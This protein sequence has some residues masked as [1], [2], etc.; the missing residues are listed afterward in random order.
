MARRRAPASPRD[1]GATPTW[2]WTG[3]TGAPKPHLVYLLQHGLP[4]ETYPPGITIDWSD[5]YTLERF[6]EQAGLLRK[7]VPGP[8][9]PPILASRQIDIAIKVLW[10]PAKRPSD[11]A[12][13]RCFR[14]IME[15][16]LDDPPSQ[17]WMITELERRLGAPPGRQR[18]LD[19]W[20]RIAPK[21]R[22]RKGRRRK[23]ISAKKS[24]A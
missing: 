8:R 17:T 2:R 7:F 13:E 20:E 16:R 3:E 9:V 10:P 1:K 12:V 24:A 19:L 18:V 15:E 5:A 4:Y 21:W 23:E 11:A 6:D 14:K 22:P